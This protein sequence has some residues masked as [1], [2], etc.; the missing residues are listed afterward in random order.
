MRVITHNKIPKPGHRRQPREQFGRHDALFSQNF[1][2][3][4]IAARRSVAFLSNDMLAYIQA[5]LNRQ[6]QRSLHSTPDQ[7]IFSVFVEISL[8]QLP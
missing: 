8:L 4:S 1:K 2:N 6:M 5:S 7:D 3:F